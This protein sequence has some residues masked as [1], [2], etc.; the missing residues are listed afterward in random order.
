MLG[1]I[2]DDLVISSLV[3]EDC[4]V[5][6]LFNLSLSPLLD[7]LLLLTGRLGDLI[8]SLSFDCFSLS[9][10]TLTIG[11]INI[12]YYILYCTIFTLSRV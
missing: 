6:L 4:I 1:D 9:Y 11:Y 12:I 3:E 7:T 8:L 2:T 10:S 5:D